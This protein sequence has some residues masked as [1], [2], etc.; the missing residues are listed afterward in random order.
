MLNEDELQKQIDLINQNWEALIK[1]TEAGQAIV[2]NIRSMGGSGIVTHDCYQTTYGWGDN[3][4][5]V[6][7]INMQADI[8]NFTF[9]ENRSEYEASSGLLESIYQFVVQLLSLYLPEWKIGKRDCRQHSNTWWMEIEIKNK[10][11]EIKE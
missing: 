6:I 2:K 11:S 5:I 10:A 4:Y 9:N 8:R 3:E 1:N 7:F